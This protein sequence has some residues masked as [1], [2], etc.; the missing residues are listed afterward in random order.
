MKVLT[1][2]AEIAAN[3]IDNPLEASVELGSE[4]ALSGSQNDMGGARLMSRHVSSEGGAPLKS[5]PLRLGE[6]KAG[7]AFFK[8]IVGPSATDELKLGA[9]ESIK[10]FKPTPTIRVN[11]ADLRLSP[12]SPRAVALGGVTSTGFSEPDSSEEVRAI[13]ERGQLAKKDSLDARHSLPGRESPSSRRD[14]IN[15]L[16]RLHQHNRVPCLG[17]RVSW[18]TANLLPQH[19]QPS[20]D[21][22]FLTSLPSSLLLPSPLF[23]PSPSPHSFFSF[24]FLSSH[25][26]SL[27]L[28]LSLSLSLSATFSYSLSLSLFLVSLVHLHPQASEEPAKRRK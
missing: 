28:S 4:V 7:S 3:V 26:P 13:F 15:Q 6:K 5:L 18:E 25:S 10:L 19:S 9:A 20:I 11:D 23:S 16:Q 17:G 12:G 1:G 22:C 24:L 2:P 8:P 21:S 27:P 14:S